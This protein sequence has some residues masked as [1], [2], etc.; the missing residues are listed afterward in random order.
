[1]A[2][3]LYSKCRDENLKNVFKQCAAKKKPR[4]WKEGMRAINKEYSEGNK[5]LLTVGKRL[6]NDDRERPIATK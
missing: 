1:M 4:R 2:E 5:F 6:E 3:N